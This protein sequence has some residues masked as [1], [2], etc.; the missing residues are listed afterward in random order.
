MG[1]MERIAIDLGLDEQLFL[2]GVKYIVFDGH[3][4]YFEGIKG[5]KSFSEAEIQ[6][7][8]K[9]GSIIVEGDCLKIKK[10]C[11]GDVALTGNIK[12]VKR[13]I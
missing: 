4:A 2:S 11:R 7:Y 10:L 1:L 8:L 5:I 3:S 12:A 9:K 6:L 13:E